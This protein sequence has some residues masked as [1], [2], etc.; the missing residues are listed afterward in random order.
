MP[1]EKLIPILKN[2]NN[3]LLVVHENPDGDGI[4]SVLALSLVLKQLKKKVTSVCQDK[5]PNIFQFL[6]YASKIK[7]D[8]LLGDYDV[9]IVL[10]CGDLRRTGFPE[11]I[12]QF[13]RNKKKLVNIDHHPKNDL[14]KIAKINLYNMEAS[15]TCEILYHIFKK[16]KARIDPKIATC[17]F[18][19]LYTDTGGFKHSNTNAKTLEIASHLLS[20]GANL[21]QITKNIS[22]NKSVPA[23]RLW[24][25]ALSRINKNEDLGLVTSVITQKDMKKCQ[26]TDVD[27]AGVVNLINSISGS[28]AAILFSETPDGKIRASLRTEQDKVDVSKLAYFFEG[29][30]HRKA[31]G[32]KID[33]K[34]VKSGNSWKIEKF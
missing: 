15:S 10:D 23:L 13:A 25:I 5:I 20:L 17:L 19:G 18:T 8:F 21:R 26:A 1:I 11:R 14:H 9:I 2:Y 4:A 30:G 33:G 7:D 6:P 28:T 24:G 27:L 34:I 22:L 29:G 16:L 3:F 31:S 12:K 32:F